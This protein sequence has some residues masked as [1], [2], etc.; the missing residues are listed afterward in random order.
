MG[1][2]VLHVTVVPQL[3]RTR[4]VAARPRTNSFCPI[5]Q[6][7]YFI[8][9]LATAPTITISFVDTQ[10]ENPPNVELPP[11]TVQMASIYATQFASTP[12]KLPSDGYQDVTVCCAAS[13]S[14]FYVQYKAFRESLATVNANVNQ[15]AGSSHPLDTFVESLVVKSR[16]SHGSRG[17]TA[18]ACCGTANHSTAVHVTRCISPGS[19]VAAANLR[20]FALQTRRRTVQVCGE[21]SRLFDR[22]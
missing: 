14:H 12:L 4:P 16:K 21:R 6:V 2:R 13:P 19:S 8:E 9:M 7:R 10:P 17:C 18:I 20:D 22:R 1:C 15:S 5:D 11:P 3:A